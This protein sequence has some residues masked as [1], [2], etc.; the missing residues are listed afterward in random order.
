[1]VSVKTKAKRKAEDAE[2]HEERG[3]GG[4]KKHGKVKKAKH[5]KKR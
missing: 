5:E 1:L 4:E 3:G 2:V